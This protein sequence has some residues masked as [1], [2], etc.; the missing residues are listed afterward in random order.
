[1]DNSTRGRFFRIQ[2][3]LFEDYTTLLVFLQFPVVQ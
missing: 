2:Y 1:M 3:I